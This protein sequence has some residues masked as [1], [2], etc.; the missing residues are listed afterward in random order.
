MTVNY[1]TLIT[2]GQQ[3]IVFGQETGNYGVPP[4]TATIVYQEP[5]QSIQTALQRQPYEAHE[6]VGVAADLFDMIET[7]HHSQIT[8]TTPYRANGIAA[9]ALASIM[10]SSQSG[11]SDVSGANSGGS[12]T[13]SAI[14][15]KNN[16]GNPDPSFIN[17]AVKH[18]ITPASLSNNCN[19]LT[20]W[21]DPGDAQFAGNRSWLMMNAC[22]VEHVKLSFTPNTA[23][24]A[25][26]V[27]TGNFPVWRDTS[28]TTGVQ[29]APPAGY[30]QIGK[31]PS[32]LKASRMMGYQAQNFLIKNAQGNAYTNKILS[33]E[34]TIQRQVEVIE[35]PYSQSPTYYL[36]GPVSI[37]G[38][39]DMLFD[40]LGSVA[41][42]SD[43]LASV[44]A[45]GANNAPGVTPLNP[46]NSTIYEDY[47]AFST[48]GTSTNV[49][50]ITY[51]DSDYYGFDI[52]FYPVKMNSFTINNS[53]QSLK[54][55]IGFTSYNSLS[56]ALTS[57]KISA[58]SQVTL[59]N[60][61]ASSMIV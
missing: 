9:W 27:L 47:L 14:L 46:T 38:T 8:I 58:I 29:N 40:G 16:G 32:T 44:N 18:L 49:H 1:P 59:Y 15:A 42:S 50:Q 2:P 45:Y 48:M 43:P 35:S 26:I 12:A 53:G 6:Y 22:T 10:G 56:T 19:T 61:V 39:V 24:M 54:A 20:V 5:C 21:H 3:R 25:E 52:Q 7:T 17:T 57:G 41:G 34:I 28:G 30:N 11:A 23:V 37:M 33:G 60:D 4:S 31:T 55:N 13:P 51:V 36:P